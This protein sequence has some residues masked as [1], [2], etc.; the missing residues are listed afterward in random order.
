M[1]IYP[2]LLTIENIAAASSNPVATG[3]FADIYKAPFMSRVVCLKTIRLTGPSKV[4]HLTKVSHCPSGFYPDN[5]LGAKGFLERSHPLGSI[6]APEFTTFLWGLSFS[7]AG[8]PC[9][10]LGG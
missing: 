1:G 7:R 4:E 3:G 9:V 10:A 2:K 6:I 5:N 8:M